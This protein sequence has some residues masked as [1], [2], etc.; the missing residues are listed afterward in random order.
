MS[1]I[2][3][4][5]ELRALAL[6]PRGISPQRMSWPALKNLV[7]SD[8]MRKAPARQRRQAHVDHADARGAIAKWAH[9]HI[10][11]EPSESVRAGGDR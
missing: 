3:T 8:L 5:R 10:S 7:C 4:H 6:M 2:L 1:R 11:R 9:A